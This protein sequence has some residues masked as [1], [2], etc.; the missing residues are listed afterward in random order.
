MLVYRYTVNSSTSSVKSVK[1]KLFLICYGILYQNDSFYHQKCKNNKID[2]R[3]DITGMY[4]CSFF[5]SDVDWISSDT[6]I[7]MMSWNVNIPLII[8]YIPPMIVV[9][10][11]IISDAIPNTAKNTSMITFSFSL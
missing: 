6:S 5:F 10:L 4:I 9:P 8:K 7:D 2:Y 11:L 1:S 3:A